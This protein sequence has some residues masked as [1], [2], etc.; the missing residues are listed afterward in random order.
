MPSDAIVVLEQLHCIKLLNTES[1]TE[2]YIWPALI[3]VDDNT[4]ASGNVLQL[5]APVVGN[6]RVVIKD[7]MRAGQTASIPSSVGILR[8][9]FDD[10]L[11]THVLILVVALLENDETPRDAVDAGFRAFIEALREEIIKNIFDLSA[12][13]ED[14]TKVIA[15]EIQENVASRVKSAT[16]DALSAYEKAKVFAGILNLDDAL[17]SDFTS[18]GKE[19]LASAPIHLFFEAKGKILGTFDTLS[20]FEINGQLQVKPVVIDRCQSQVNA[21]REAQ[22]VVDGIEEEISNLQDQ[23]QGGGDE[24]PLPKDFIND[25]I[26]RIRKEELAP[27]VEA[28]NAARAALNFCRAR[29]G[30]FPDLGGGV[31]TQA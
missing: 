1:R 8:T 30:T 21:V 16:E 29:Q 7:S 24:P 17:G 2:P 6:A 18:F 19:T 5:T 4:I 28:L 3:R 23:L 13:D 14:E 12:A 9:R 11:M 15:E 22:A 27:A 31:L 20:Q 10:D 26:E 25:E